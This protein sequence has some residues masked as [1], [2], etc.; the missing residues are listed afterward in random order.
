[1][2]SKVKDSVTSVNKLFLLRKQTKNYLIPTVKSV[3]S[4]N[5]SL[6]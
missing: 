5:K 6:V 1:M 4:V 3:T 2:W